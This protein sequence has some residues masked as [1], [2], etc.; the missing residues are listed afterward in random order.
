MDP[1]MVASHMPDCQPADAAYRAVTA[2][3]AHPLELLG[4]AEAFQ[5]R[6]VAQPGRFQCQGACF[7]SYNPGPMPL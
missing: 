3:P 6:L 5:L 1:L 2:L 4:L 7:L